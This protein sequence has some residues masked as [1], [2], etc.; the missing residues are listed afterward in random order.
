MSYDIPAIAAVMNQ[1]IMQ[2]DYVTNNLSNAVTPGYK[3]EHLKYLKALEESDNITDNNAASS[4]L[5][6]DFTQG[7]AQKT[8][9]PLDL[10]LQGEGFFVVQ[11]KDGQAFTRKGDFTVN[12]QNQI[13]TQA[14]DPVM[15]EG[16]P[17]TLRNGKIN[18]S[19][20]GAVYVDENQVGK[21]KIVDFADRQSLKNVG[22]GVFLD[23]GSAAIKK[24]EKPKIASGFIELSNVNVVREM[25]DMINIDRSFEAYQKIILTLADQDKLATSRIGRIT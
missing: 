2:L 16:G 24:V 7:M 4:T 8:D 19:E 13:V 18:V 10:Q 3:A 6:V 1:K 23:S 25:A 14:G 17:I 5:I 21:L 11:T 20:D 15:G 12:K 9:N 22:G